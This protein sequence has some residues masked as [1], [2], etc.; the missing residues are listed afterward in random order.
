M[1]YVTPQQARNMG[2][3]RL[4]LSEGVPGPWGEAAKGMF[5]V[6]GIEFVP[7]AQKPL[8]PNEE[9][10]AWT[11]IRNAPV[12]VYD[13]EPPVERWIDIV[14]LAERIGRGPSLL[15]EDSELRA[16]AVGISHEL[17]GEWGFGWCQRLGMLKGMWAGA[18]FEDLSA[19]PEPMA[20][21]QCQYRVW[22]DQIAAAPSRIAAIV[23]ML[24]ARLARQKQAASPYLVGHDLT[25]AD[26][27]W[28]CFSA[29]LE[30]M[31]HALNPMPEGLRAVYDAHAP[32][33]DDAVKAALLAHR[34]YVYHNH[35][36]LPLDF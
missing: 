23:D 1:E 18:G 3:L 32:V 15:P 28:A 17:C 22:P 10:V 36:R 30:P 26:I 9:L 13:D 19:L 12:A 4:V 5:H 11:G 29:M 33:V 16:Q 21:V 27:H 14:M 6:R 7:V 25:C 35:L 31:E 34:D 8:E 2:G 20:S 24:A